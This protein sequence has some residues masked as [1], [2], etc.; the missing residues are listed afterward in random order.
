MT[1]AALA[2]AWAIAGTA[3]T[4]AAEI[5]RTADGS[6]EGKAKLV[7]GGVRL[8]DRT[9]QWSNV[10]VFARP[11]A[12][13]T[14]R[15]RQAVRLIDG[16]RWYAR[17]TGATGGKLVIES[18][19]FGPRQVPLARIASIEF[20][21]GALS[22]NRTADRTLYRRTGEPIPGELL[23]IRNDGVAIDSPLGVITFPL[24]Q[25]EA[26]VFSVRAATKVKP[27]ESDIVALIDGTILRGA[28]SAADGRAII[29][30][31]MLGKLALPEAAIRAVRR[32]PAHVT[33]LTRERMTGFETASL[34]DGGEGR[35]A[36]FI[37]DASG[38]CLDVL[39]VEP[40]TTVR[41][42]LPGG[43]KKGSAFRASVSPVPGARG[44]VVLRV[45]VDGKPAGERK[46]TATA[47]PSSVTVDLPRGEQLAIEVDFT[48]KPGFPSGVMLGDACLTR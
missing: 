16:Q 39:R 29:E 8:G 36:R 10:F 7:D 11:D 4:R 40:H 9:I 26:Y 31:A 25:A 1:A 33:Y 34:I 43:V 37:G 30:H 46:I 5:V 14:V 23:W 32:E 13:P 24:D 2:V 47:G 44:D 19:M 45:R 42:D 27:G 28:T 3:P 20:A 6:V 21:S 12:R 17:V 22:I 48:G 35:T 15:A 41:F 18:D 38:R